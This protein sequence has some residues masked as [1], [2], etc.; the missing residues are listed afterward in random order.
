MAAPV[1]SGRTSSVAEHLE[2][3]LVAV[4]PLAPVNVPLAEALGRTLA[5][6]AFAHVDVPG[7]DNSAM[8]GY[9]V[10][11]AD[12]ESAT[13]ESP[14]VLNV[15]A[16]LP[17]GSDEN[18]RLAPG[19][20]A[21]IMTGAAIPDNA[22]C[23]VPVEHTDA[24]TTSVQITRAPTPAAHIRPMG[25]DVRVGETVLSAGTV[26]RP[27]HL[28][29]AAATGLS[30][31]TVYRAPR[32]GVLS[33]G[34]ELTPP[35]EPL[36]RGKIHDSNSF[37][38]ET[39]VAEAGGIPVRIGS[40]PDSEDELRRV[41]DEHAG[42]VDAFITSGGV[43]V[44]AYDVVKAALA[45][46]GA[47]FGPVRMQPGKPQ[48]FG[49]WTDGTPIFALPGNP[50]SV[51]VSFEAFVRPALL[52]LQGRGDL[53]RPVL[54]GVVAEGWRSP[55]GRAQYMPIV[56]ARPGPSG[57]RDDD[58]GDAN[59]HASAETRSGDRRQGHGQAGRPGTIE[60]RPASTGGSGSYLVTRLARADG[61]AL[62]PEDVTEVRPGDVLPVTLV[63]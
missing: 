24:G 56:V 45:P 11:H 6:A 35:G 21:R 50:V 36:G 3:I 26:L 59:R 13:A 30:E 60:V 55:A 7:F 5:E 8:D 37:L 17:A 19:Q 52:K 44:G 42:R 23:I 16:D 25:S 38:L 32:V 31:L 20:A 40:V 63:E 15:V 39:A 46:L 27:T 34:S 12:V 10:R 53:E 4:E 29:A 33:T 28:A 49:A 62:V 61:L 54:Q 2:R 57:A 9:A 43:S 41:L 18:P 48:G 51:F 58:A 47:W 22:D 1:L 14:V